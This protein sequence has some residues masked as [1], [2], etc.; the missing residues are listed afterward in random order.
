MKE[1]LIRPMTPGDNPG[2]AALIRSVLKDLGVPETG[3]AYADESLNDLFTFYSGP[4][5]VYLVVEADGRLVGGGGI[6]PLKEGPHNVCELQKMYFDAGIR[7]RGTGNRMLLLLLLKAEDFGYT[8]CY[9]ETMPYMETA[10]SLYRKFGFGY[11]PAPMGNTGHHSCQLWML[12]NL[13]T[14]R[15]L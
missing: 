7:G 1:V 10:Q 12:L 14:S 9:L 13:Q 2:I 5:S 15:V 11:L 8:R 6:A 4:R 3:T